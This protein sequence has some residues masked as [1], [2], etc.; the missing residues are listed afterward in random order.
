MM[1]PRDDLANSLP[2][3]LDAEQNLLG[4]LLFDNEVFHRLERMTPEQFSEPFHQRLFAAIIS[5]IGQ[6]NLAEATVIADALRA[7]PAFE[8][9]G[10][11]NY[12]LNLV[13]HAPAS[14]NAPAY[15]R[16]IAEHA[17]RRQ[18]AKLGDQL[19]GEAP[20][21][22]EDPLDLIGK[23]E[24]SLLAMQVSNSE[25]RLYSA[26]EASSRVLAELDTPKDHRKGIKTGLE[27]LD[28]MLGPLLPGDLVLLMGRPSMGK[29]A[30]AECVAVNMAAPDWQNYV[31]N[32]DAM[33]EAL[34][35]VIQVNGEMSPEQMA[36]RHLT[37]IAF[38]AWQAK[39]PK[40]SDIRKGEVNYDQRQMLGRADEVL[41]RMPISML[42]RRLKLSE[43]RSLARR[44]AAEWHR[45]GIGLSALIIDHVGLLKPDGGRMDRYEAQTEI[46]GGLKELA[47]ELQCVVI[48]LNQMN[49]ENEKRDDKRPQLSD[50]RDSG[51]WEQDADFVIGFY[52]E[53]YYAQRQPEPKKD[54]EWDAWDRARKSRTIEALV[55]KAREGE[56]GTAMLWGDVARNAIRGIEPEGWLL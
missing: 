4:I 13:D 31:N 30:V 14:A 7:D 56:C 38:S 44:Q 32:A 12:L 33:P 26:G 2:G 34:N 37:D 55:L 48:G 41:Q 11:R 46:S 36:R 19:R 54:L 18:I 40:Y 6:G 10:G 8:P 17:L 24:A 3:N 28:R 29:S 23:A 49:R 45:R 27:P 15:A 43:L 21:P 1:D 52:R 42:R 22:D 47:A 51:S 5:R 25:T 35:G 39:G 16:L 50:L 9:F 20:N 53:A